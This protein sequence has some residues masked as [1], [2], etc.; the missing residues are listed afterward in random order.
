MTMT[1]RWVL[2]LKRPRARGSGMETRDR[3]AGFLHQRL[4]VRLELLTAGPVEEQADLD[5]FLC[6]ARQCLRHPPA[7]VTGPP[8]IGLDVDRLGRALQIRQKPIEELSVLSDLDAVAFDQRAAGERDDRRQ[9]LFERRAVLR[10]ELEGAVVED[11]P[12]QQEQRAMTASR[13]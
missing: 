13:P 7:D 8:H 1:L 11:R 5:A 2:A 6:L 12:Q 3:D 9:L 10:L 4:Q